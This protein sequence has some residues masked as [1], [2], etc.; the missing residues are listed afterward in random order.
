MNEEE[1]NKKN[2]RTA[3]VVSIVVHSV[4]LLAF[5]FILAWKEPDPPLPEYGVELNFGLDNVGSGAIQPEIEAND[6]ESEEEAVPEEVAEVEEVVDAEVEPVEQEVVEEAIV[7]EV[8]ESTDN[9]QESPDVVN[10]EVEET[11]KEPVKEPVPEPKEEVKEPVKQ[12]E[13]KEVINP[14]NGAN[15]KEGESTTEQ[16]ANNG[17]DTD[18]VGDKGDENG[19]LD[20]RALYGKSG[21]GGGSALDMAGWLWDFKPK[22]KDTSS[23]NGRIVFEIKIDDQGE[24]LSV[25]TIERSVS[26]TVEKIYRAEVEKLTFSKTSDNSAAAPISTGRITFVIKS[27]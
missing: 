5:L 20:A 10:K 8:E 9:V 21:G 4:L 18:K 24:I 16:A 17:D 23:E 1:Q 19:T 25:R 22:P 26:P 3:T 15:G 7:E 27:Q 12:P 6:S 2:K 14:E 13:V 11:P